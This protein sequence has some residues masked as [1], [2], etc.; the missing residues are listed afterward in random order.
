MNTMKSP[1]VLGCFEALITQRNICLQTLAVGELE[2]H[3]LILEGGSMDEEQKDQIT[4]TAKRLQLPY[5]E[6]PMCSETFFTIKGNFFF[7]LYSNQTSL[8]RLPRRSTKPIVTYV[9]K[10]HSH[11]S[12][13]I[14]KAATQYKCEDFRQC[15][16]GHSLFYKE[17]HLPYFYRQNHN[18][19]KEKTINLGFLSVCQWV[20]ACSILPNKAEFLIDITIVIAKSLIT[21]S[22]KSVGYL[23]RPDTAFISVLNYH[24]H[25]IVIS[26][27]QFV[28]LIHV[29]T[30]PS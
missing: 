25:Y 17:L 24:L 3:L 22:G 19:M 28:L 20:A 11:S 21:K 7:S 5:A 9:Q 27:L 15:F 18:K 14:S 6:F 10:L 12:P 26:L 8:V 16:S 13:Y 2:P 30:N 23:W 4:S 1:E 29:T